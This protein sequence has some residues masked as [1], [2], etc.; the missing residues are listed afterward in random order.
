MKTRALKLKASDYAYQMSAELQTVMNTVLL[1]F[2]NVSV[3]QHS[4]FNGTGYDWQIGFRVKPATLPLVM[5]L[6]SLTGGYQTW[7]NAS[8]SRHTTLD[9]ALKQALKLLTTIS[10]RK[11]TFE[12]I[13][14]KLSV[15]R[16]TRRV[17]EKKKSGP[18]RKNTR[19]GGVH[20]ARNR[21]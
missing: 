7:G 13:F 9:P 20:A 21:R 12:R 8:Y 19:P 17:N 14:P 3:S 10:K 15:T 5:I 2:P 11:T 6:H 1:Y 4:S 18:A 16:P